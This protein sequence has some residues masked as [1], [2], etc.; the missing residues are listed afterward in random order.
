MPLSRPICQQPFCQ[1]TAHQILRAW[2]YTGSFKWK[3]ESYHRTVVL[4]FMNGVPVITE[5]KQEKKI[6]KCRIH[7]LERF[8]TKHD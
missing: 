4:A 8:L 5:H 7:E 1:L 2:G 6:K 3:K